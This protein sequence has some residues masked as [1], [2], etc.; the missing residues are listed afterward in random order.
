MREIFAKLF[1]VFR[2]RMAAG[3]ASCVRKCWFGLQGMR[4][5]HGT[6]LP[7]IHV[8]WP[9]KVRLGCGCHLEHGI[10]FKYDGIYSPG[11]AITIGDR[12]FIGSGCEFNV[13]H[14][15][16]VGSES[17]IASGCRFVDHDHGMQRGV[18][19]KAQPC[20]GAPI[21]IGRD[22]W[23]GCN[24]VVLKGVSVGD[25]AVVAAGAVVRADVPAYEIWGGV[26]AR[27]IGERR[28]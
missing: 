15:V 16:S 26:P 19:M 20:P 5:G 14:S 13:R 11:T 17:L 1:F 22:V 28:V 24:V 2:L 4:T 12:V 21:T 7:K 18:A 6:K 27:K 3:A 8:T 10:W 9:H 23:L 25:G